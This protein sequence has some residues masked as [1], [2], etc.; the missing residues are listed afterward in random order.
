MENRTKS[1]KKIE[2]RIEN[3][4]MGKNCEKDKQLLD[5]LFSNGNIAIPT[6]LK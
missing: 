5:E 6:K 3:K 4:K 2:W 1:E